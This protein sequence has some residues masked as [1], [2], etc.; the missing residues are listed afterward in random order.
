ML[1]LTPTTIK[2]PAKTPFGIVCNTFNRD[3]VMV[4]MSARPIKK[5]VT[6][7]STT[8]VALTWGLR[9]SEP[10]PS[11]VGIITSSVL[12]SVRE[13]VCTGA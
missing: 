6:L 1:A 2:T 8:L 4:P 9:I 11:D 3:P 12:Y 7:C 13:S 10:S 5:C